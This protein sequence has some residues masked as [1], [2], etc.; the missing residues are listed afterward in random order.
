MV[1]RGGA[2]TQETIFQWLTAQGNC[3]YLA[4]LCEVTMVYGTLSD[5]WTLCLAGSL[6]DG[7]PHNV[8]LRYIL[9]YP[10][11]GQQIGFLCS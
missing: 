9:K 3:N 5:L 7:S 1:W 10:I 11:Q 2:V 4:S 6:Y 8:S